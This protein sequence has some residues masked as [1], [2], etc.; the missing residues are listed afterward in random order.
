MLCSRCNRREVPLTL[1]GA[2]LCQV[3]NVQ[4][5]LLKKEETLTDEEI[6]EYH[7][8]EVLVKGCR[9][10]GDME[11]GYEAGV[12]E[13]NGLKWFVMKVH[14]G[15]CNEYYEE[16]LEVKIDESFKGSEEE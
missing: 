14:C 10:C 7:L 3:C 11:F 5:A 2:S 1:Q 12:Q 4:V 15:A 9:E 8:T 16:I 13:E 6:L